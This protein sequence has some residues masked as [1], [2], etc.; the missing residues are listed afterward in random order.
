MAPAAVLIAV[1]AYSLFGEALAN[2]RATQGAAAAAS[3]SAVQ[4]WLDAAGRS[5]A[6]EAVAAGYID[7]DRCS[8]LAEAFLR[9]NPGFS[10]VSFLDIASSPC[11][12]G[13]SVDVAKLTQEPGV[14]GESEAGYRVFAIGARLW[15]VTAPKPAPN[16]IGSV[17]VVDDAALKD[18]L[19]GESDS[20]NGKSLL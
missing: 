8:Q 18:R 20:E 16:K 19:H 2:L 17:L 12:A 6:N 15:I 9:R 3:A 4:S 14:T 10:G 13:E 7:A 5:L 11:A 1:L